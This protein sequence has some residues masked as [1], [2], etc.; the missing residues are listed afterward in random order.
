MTKRIP[1]SMATSQKI[2]ELL[3]GG[4]KAGEGDL[5]GQ[6][7]QLAIRKIIE[8]ALEA[9]A[10]EAMRRGYYQ[11]S[12]DPV[13]PPDGY[14]NGTRRGRLKT[15]EG[16][17]EYGVPQIADRSEPFVS[18]IRPQLKGRSEQLEKLAIEMYARGLSVRDIEATFRGPEGKT[19]LSKAAICEVTEKLWQEYEAF[20]TR[21]LTDFRIAYL[22]LDGM[23]ERL[24]PGQRREA[25]LCAWGIDFDGRKHL[26]NLSPGTKEDTQSVRAFL[27]DLKRRGLCDPLFVNTDGAGGFI[28]AVEEVFPR[29]LRGRCLAHKLRNLQSKVKEEHWEEF[30]AYV[31]ACYEAPSPETARWLRDQLVERFEKSQPSAVACFLEDF[32]ACIAHLRFPL[33]HRKAIRTTNLLERLFEEERRRTKVMPHAFG[34]RPMLKV[35]YAAVIRASNTWKK[36]AMTAF[37]RQQLEIIGQE[38]ADEFRRHHEPAA[39]KKTPSQFS[40]KIGT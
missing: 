7:I 2:Q 1:A 17:I 11:R 28:R 9:E 8:E 6:F 27:Q 32:E 31:S 38:L 18:Q 25:V 20:A 30:K 4:L 12:V 39:Q 10:A 19:L 16:P 35:M 23:A 33:T 22:F 3:T 26:L 24:S 21:E 13:S 40:S 29:S 34:E 36:I 37:E 5:T 14:R 15:A